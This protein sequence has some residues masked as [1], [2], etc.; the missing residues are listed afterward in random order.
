[1]TQ[2]QRLVTACAVVAFGFAASPV[3]RAAST[4]SKTTY[5]TFTRP[6]MLPG[7]A[8]GSGTYTFEIPDPQMAWDVVRVSSRDRRVVYYSGF[9]R[10][11]PRPAGLPKHQTVSFAEARASVPQPIAVWW[12]SNDSFGRQFIYPDRR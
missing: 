12:P 2:R 1:M 6:V 9:T 8:L 7:V 3:G 11:V 4:S 5:L 10:V